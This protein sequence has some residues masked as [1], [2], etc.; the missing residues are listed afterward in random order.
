MQCEFKFNAK[1]CFCTLILVVLLQNLVQ[2]VNPASPPPPPPAPKPPP[3]P[4][5]KPPSGP[6]LKPLTGLNKQSA[7]LKPLPLMEPPPKLKPPPAPKSPLVPKPHPVDPKPI[8]GPNIVNIQNKKQFDDRVLGASGKKPV[9][10]QFHAPWCAPCNSLGP[11]LAKAVNPHDD[12]ITLARVNIVPKEL[13]NVAVSQGVFSIPIVASYKDGKI[14][15]KMI[16]AHDE[17][18]VK[19][20]VNKQVDKFVERKPAPKPK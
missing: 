17:K 11:N 19:A 13:H 8:E 7:V 18:E 6:V 14:V 3:G 9:I 4:A 12:K 16:G 20:F 10:T 15:D 1:L 2:V 5:P